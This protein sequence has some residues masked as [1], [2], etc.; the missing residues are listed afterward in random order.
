MGVMARQLQER[1]REHNRREAIPF[2]LLVEQA[3]KT[4]LHS[5]SLYS[6]PLTDNEYEVN[7]DLE[8][9]DDN[10][11]GGNANRGNDALTNMYMEHNKNISGATPA[12]DGSGD[13]EATAISSDEDDDGGDSR[14]KARGCFR[15]RWHFEVPIVIAANE[16]YHSSGTMHPEIRFFCINLN[17]GFIHHQ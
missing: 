14:D 13:G 10:A 17:R 5:Y 15:H 12:S 3:Y 8:M 16:G 4:V 1:Y 2:R 6:N 11:T 7:S 9:M